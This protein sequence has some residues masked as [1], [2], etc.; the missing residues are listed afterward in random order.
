MYF[1]GIDC[2][3]CHAVLREQWGKEEGV[4]RA[5]GRGRKGRVRDKVMVEVGNSK[6]DF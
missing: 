5:R 4:E 6:C 1:Y 2:I 3:V